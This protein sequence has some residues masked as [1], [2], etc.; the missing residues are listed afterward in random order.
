[1]NNKIN[2][3][4]ASSS[5]LAKT[6]T[7]IAWILGLA[8]AMFV[9]QEVLDYQWN[10]NQTP[11]SKLNLS[12]KAQ[13][14]LKQNNSGHYI[15]TGTIN[16]NPVVFLLDT[17]ATQVSIPAHIAQTL[18]LDTYGQYPVQ[19]ANGTV[20]VYRT[21]IESLSIGNLHLYNISAHINPGM[22]SDEILLG[23]SALKKVE[24]SQSGK[25]LTL[26]ER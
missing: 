8:V 22:Q 4:E 3:N 11:Q 19:T 18:N 16:S 1:M 17:G 5:G 10:P 14:K 9:F 12:G 23:M 15:T 21:K 25:E 20:T 13:V 24:F 2:N 6:F 26:V 7:W